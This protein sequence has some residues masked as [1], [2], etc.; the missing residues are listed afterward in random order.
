MLADIK[1]NGRMRKAAIQVTK[2]ALVFAFDR[3]TGEPLFPI[4]ETPVPASTVPTEKAAADAF[5]FRSS[6]RPL[7]RQGITED[8]LIDF[9]PALHAEAV[10]I[11][12]RY[13]HGAIFHAAVAQ[14][15]PRWQAGHALSARLGRRGQLDRGRARSGNRCDVRP[16]C[17]CALACWHGVRRQG[18]LPPRARNQSLSGWSARPLR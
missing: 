4:V 10:E 1:V 6:R 14:G 17:Q 15:R 11:M 9:T 2:T 5:V 12:N 7:D 16:F 8:Q 18:W 3:A 13:V